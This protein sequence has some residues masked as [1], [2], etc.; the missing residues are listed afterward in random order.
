MAV[1]PLGEWK[2][3]I[4]AGAFVAPSAEVMGRVKIGPRAS[5]WYQCVLRGDLEPIE[6][7]A[8][9]NIQ[10]GTVM[11]TD[12]DQPVVIGEGVTVGHLALIH[13]ARVGDYSLIGMSAVLL[14]GARIGAGSIVAAGTLVPEG[15]E[16]PPGVLVMG[17]PFQVKR[18]LSAEEKE[19][20]RLHAERYAGWAAQHI[21]WSAAAGKRKPRR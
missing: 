20:L 5:V 9:S 18:E 17:R 8:L 15:K 12:H 16:V 1:W 11:H 10:D 4:A 2:P 21:E 7:G 6:I 13:G 19:G 3:E 14:N